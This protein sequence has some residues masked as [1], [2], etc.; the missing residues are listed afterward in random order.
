MMKLALLRMKPDANK[1]IGRRKL[2]WFAAGVPCLLMSYAL[3][4]GPVAKLQDA[5]VIGEGADQTLAVIYAPLQLLGGIPGMGRSFNWYI[6][7]FW[8][9]DNMGDLTL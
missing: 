4:I 8:N 7:H 9:C 6:F 5:R 1:S 2:T 3:S